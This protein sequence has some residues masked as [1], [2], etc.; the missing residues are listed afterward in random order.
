MRALP[1]C[2]LTASLAL[3]GCS[4]LSRPA[5]PIKPLAAD[6][7]PETVAKPRAV[8]PRQTPITLYESAEDLIGKPFRDLGEVSGSVCQTRP[9]HSAPSL[10]TA[11]KRMLY[12][13]AQL[14][15]NAVLLHSCQILSQS[16]GCYRQATCT[17]SAL[18]I[19]TP[20]Q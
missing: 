20:A 10:T 1:L 9:H 13:A 2:L 8:T 4:L 6:R 15:A 14:K 19:A 18:S 12:K 16:H 5:A 11:R 17:G 7:T 3:S